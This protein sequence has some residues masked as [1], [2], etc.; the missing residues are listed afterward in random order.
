MKKSISIGL[1]IFSLFFM[2]A[3]PIKKKPKLV[4][5]TCDNGYEFEYYEADGYTQA[6][7]DDMIDAV[8]SQENN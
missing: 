3:A 2:S 8:C 4:S 1:F 6:D 5:H 7:Y